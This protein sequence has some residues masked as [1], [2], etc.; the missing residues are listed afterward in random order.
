[1]VVI[2]DTPNGMCY[3]PLAAVRTGSR[4]PA[5]K[6]NRRRENADGFA[7]RDTALERD[8]GGYQCHRST[9]AKVVPVLSEYQRVLA[10][11]KTSK[12]VTLIANQTADVLSPLVSLFVFLTFHKTPRAQH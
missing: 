1:M 11:T 12:F 4:P 3:T 9:G 6:P 2:V 10:E 8:K 5:V 7:I